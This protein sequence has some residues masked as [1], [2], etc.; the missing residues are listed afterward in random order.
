MN[1]LDRLIG[2]I[3]P[4]WGARR[5]SARLMLDAHSRAYAAAKHGRRNKGWSG[6]STSANSEIGSSLRELRNRSREFARDSWAGQRMLDVLVSHVVGTGIVTVPNTGNDR[7]DNAVKLV[8]E[9]WGE[10]ADVEE[11]LDWSG[12]QALAVRSMIEGGDTVV[13]FID[14]SPA[15]A[16]RTVP[17]RLLGLEGDQIDTT[18]DGMPKSKSRLGVELGAWGRRTGLW[19]HP[20]HPGEFT[21]APGASSLVAWKDLAHVYRPLRFGQVRGVPWFASILLTARELQDIVEATL[22]KMR[23]EASFAGFIKRTSGGMSPLATKTET[24]GEKLTR[25]EPGMI[26]D[27]GDG[28]ITFANPSSQTAFGEVYM[29]ATMA[30]AAGAGITYDQLTGDLRQANYS[31]L[32]AG[33][34]EFRR[35]VEQVQ[36]TI[37]VPRLI[38]PAHRRLIER[39]ILA[40]KIRDRKEGFPLDHIMPAVEPIDPKKDLEADILAVRAGRLSPQEFIAAWGR[41]WRKVVA[42]TA[43]FM[44]HLDKQR[45]GEG[46]TLDIDARKP[47]KGTGNG[48]QAKP[49]ADE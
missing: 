7:I 15:D 16:G 29:S 47:M 48:G 38:A 34:I 40:G 8:F 35:L 5:A 26:A 37:A 2:A 49:D 43:A 6:R 41:D 1:P 28:E 3:S 18:R 27:I 4:V 9:E 36:W 39:A 42:D 22:V 10:N 24:T 11:L 33:K 45:A 13:R 19:L 25:I 12:I 30:M 21:A 20:D 17:F 31:S 44:E 14:I 46:L 23:T 32:R